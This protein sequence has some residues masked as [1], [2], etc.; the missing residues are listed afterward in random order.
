MSIYRNVALA[1]LLVCLGACASKGIQDIYYSLAPGGLTSAA[2]QSDHQRETRLILASVTLPQFLQKQN[3]VM[4]K[5]AHTLVHARHHFWAEPLEDGIAKVLVQDIMKSSSA[6]QVEV[7]AGRWTTGSNCS[8]RLEF[9]SFHATQSGRVLS[10]GR[11]WLQGADSTSPSVQQFNY[12]NNLL[13]DGY[14]Q[15]VTQLHS[16]L[17]N[18]SST[19]ITA[20]ETSGVCRAD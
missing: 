19:I 9:D 11:F 7:N 3:L 6:L 2:T 10:A 17:Q 16:A 14:A 18:L 12:S 5:G 20:I 8:L 1:G 15:V 4:Q 13:A